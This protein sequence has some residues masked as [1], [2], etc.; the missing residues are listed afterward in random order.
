MSQ[1]RKSPSKT[2]SK[3]TQNLINQMMKDKKITWKKQKEITKAMSVGQAL[4]VE[5]KLS[6]TL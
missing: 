2:L 3:D 5:R 1:N 6:N 4:P